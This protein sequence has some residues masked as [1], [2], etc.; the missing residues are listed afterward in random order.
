MPSG[1]PPVI[2]RPGFDED[3]GF[4]DGGAGGEQVGG[5]GEEF[6][7]E[8]VDGGVEGGGDEVDV[9]GEG[10]VDVRGEEGVV[11]VLD[12]FGGEGLDFH[13]LC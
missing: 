10:G 4:A 1:L 9:G 6:V 12:C 8:G 13:C 5:W 2:P 11:G 7:G 3:A